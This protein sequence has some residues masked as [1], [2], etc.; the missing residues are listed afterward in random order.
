MPSN[1]PLAITLTAN[2]GS[3]HIYIST[4]TSL[5]VMRLSLTNTTSA[6]LLFQQYSGGGAAI[7]Q[8]PAANSGVY[9]LFN[10]LLSNTVIAGITFTLPQGWTAQTLQD[11]QNGQ[12]WVLLPSSTISLA[13][14]DELAFTLNFPS[15]SGS[16]DSGYFSCQYVNV[17]SG[18]AVSAGEQLYIMLVYPVSAASSP[19][20]PVQ[21]EFIG[22]NEVITG[23]GTNSLSF[24]ITN[25]G[26]D[27]LVPGGTNSWGSVPPQFK[28]HFLQDNSNSAGSLLTDSRAGSV[29]ISVR[30]LYN[31]KLRIDKQAST[32]PQLWVI[33][34]DDSLSGANGIILGTGA[35]AS[36]SFTVSQL[37]TNVPESITM[38]ILEYSGFPGYEDGQ[39]TAE[40]IVSNAPQPDPSIN[41]FTASAYSVNISNISNSI[42][43]SWSVSAA[44][45]I[46]LFNE[47]N[48][49]Y[50][51][52]TLS[53]NIITTIDR[54]SV[55]RL[56]ASNNEGKSATSNFTIQVD[57]IPIGT[58]M[59]WSGYSSSVPNGW[60]ICDGTNGTPNLKERFILGASCDNYTNT[61]TH[62]VNL[63]GGGGTHTHSITTNSVAVYTNTD[64]AHSHQM[65]F[66]K[67]HDVD[68]GK[69]NN[70]SYYH[71]DGS[72]TTDGDAT[73]SVHS[74]GLVIPVLYGTALGASADLP[75]FYSLY[76][77]MKCS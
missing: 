34:Q 74:H 31:N 41:S 70:N 24:R 49:I 28:L 2:D 57:T 48:L 6:S 75:P 36:V 56:V 38:A 66:D 42:T 54:T 47:N 1:Q 32:V 19:D 67:T 7:G 16:A 21:F 9:L 52:T 46:Q 29:N 51:T 23:G 14:G 65:N 4:E 71:G 68:S 45:Q 25:T 73:N 10:G 72:E 44:S 3:N 5:N 63:T 35:S 22:K 43:I 30:Q 39:L 64:G 8:L 37:A 62:Y 13:A 11:N 58:I 27:V 55:F 26:A 20:F 33:K 60:Q 40:I 12:Y 77:I 59:I 53:G 18:S 61:S 15:V 76:Y 50:T 69:N 17:L